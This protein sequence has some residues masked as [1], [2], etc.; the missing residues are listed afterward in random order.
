LLLQHKGVKT[1]NGLVENNN[2]NF[3]KL[4]QKKK[5]K[6]KNGITS[7]HSPSNNPQ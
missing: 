5:K 7:K 2:F 3:Y 6:K 4:S 1:D